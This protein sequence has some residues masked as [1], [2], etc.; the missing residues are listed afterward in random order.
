MENDT[1]ELQNKYV[2]KK[3]RKVAVESCA[4]ISSHF[5]HFHF[6]GESRKG[7]GEGYIYIYLRLF[8]LEGIQSKLINESNGS[9]SSWQVQIKN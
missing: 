9:T 2:K 5:S 8:I 6:I 3:E 1:K 7:E 4:L